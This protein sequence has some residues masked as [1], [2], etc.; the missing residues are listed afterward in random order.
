M[1]P[2]GFYQGGGNMFS[3]VGVW[4]SLGLA[5]TGLA[6]IPGI[7]VPDSILQLMASYYNTQAFILG[8]CEDLPRAENMVDLD[9]TV[10]DVYGQ[11]VARVTYHPHRHELVASRYYS[12]ILESVLATAGAEWA[13][14]STSPN[15]EGTD[16]GG[17]DSPIASSRHVVGTVRMGTDPATSVCR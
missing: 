8:V 15:P 12:G 10:K 3:P 2:P 16:L 7:P 14:S 17:Y 5:Q 1:K 6:G 9:P 13:F 11:P 4:G